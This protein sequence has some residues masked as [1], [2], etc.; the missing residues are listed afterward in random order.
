MK[1]LMISNAGEGC[2]IL[3]MIQKEGNDVQ[4]YIK[5]PQYRELWDGLLPKVKKVAPSKDTVVIFDFSSMG[6]LADELKAAGHFVVGG[7]KFADKL[8]Q[9]R[10]FGLELMEKVGIKVPLTAEFSKFDEIDDFIKENG[11]SEEGGPPRRFVFKPSGKDLPTH[12]T[13]VSIDNEDLLEYVAYVKENYSGKV[14]SFVLQE[15]VDGVV[16]ST[17]MWSDGEKFIR[18]ANHTVEVKGFMNR[19]LG[20]ATGCSGNLVWVEE[21]ICRIAANGIAR[22]EK[23]V[24]ESGYIGPIDL[25]AVVND[26]GIW[27][28]EFTPRFGYDATPTQMFL[29]KDEIG[30]FFSDIARGQLQDEMPLSD[31][32]AAAV[33][34]SIPPYPLDPPK[35]SDIQEVRP[36]VGIPIRG[37]TEKNAGSLYFYEVIEKDGQLQHSPGIGLIGAAVGVADHPCRAVDDAYGVLQSLEVPEIQYRTDLGA[38]LESMYEQVDYQDG[39][40][41]SLGV[42][43][44]V[45]LEDAG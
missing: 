13:Y 18:P 7:S 12:L 26:A 11:N 10:K 23:D 25:N 32:F 1:F 2:H 6:A 9:D 17:E 45:E 31:K 41:T 14:K 42:I 5:D 15:F 38:V 37:L 29:F 22:V 3:K 43:P 39:A 30:K 35:V 4:L 16:V 28:L 19:C 40:S 21:G 20:P 8:E 34:F 33:R 44:E 24:V 36:N 27:G